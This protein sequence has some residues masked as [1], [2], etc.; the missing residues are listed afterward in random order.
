MTAPL[1]PRRRFNAGERAAL[2]VSADGRCSDC[3]SYL[4]P[5]FHADHRTPHARGGATHVRNGAAACPTCNL[6][7]GPNTMPVPHRTRDAVRQL[8]ST[9]K[10][11]AW[12]RRV[13]AQLR[14]HEERSFLIDA[15]PGGGKTVPALIH[16]RDEIAAGR[17]ERIVIVTPT[18][19][20]ARQWALAAHALGLNIEPNWRGVVEPTNFHGIAI[21]YQRLLSGQLALAHSCREKTLVI[22]DEPHHL[23]TN[24]AWA[25]SFA[26]AFEDAPKWL[27]L[28]GTPFR[29][30]GLA[31]PGVTYEGGRAKADFSYSYTEAIHDG[32]CRAV[33]FVPYDGQLRWASDGTVI[34]ADF[35]RNLD[36]KESARRHRT[37]ISATLSDGLARMIA[38][39]NSQ[40]DQVRETH[41]NAGMLIVC[42]NI[43][44]AEQASSIAEK[45]CGEPATL[46]TSDDPEASAQI[47]AYAKGTSRCIVAVN[48]VSEGVDIPRLRVG[49]YAT[50]K[51][52]AMLFRQIVGRFTRTGDS[53]DNDCSF[54]FLPADPT[55]L[56][57]AAEVQAEIS[58]PLR[59]E[60]PE[61]LP[62]LEDDEGADEALDGGSFVPL[63]ADVH[64]Q[65]A[66]L[67]GAL[68]EDPQLAYAVDVLARRQGISP[69]EVLRSLPGRQMPQDVVASIDE[70]EFERRARLAKDRDRLARRLAYLAGMEFKDVHQTV[71][72]MV[73]GGKPVK[74][75]TVDQLTAGIEHLEREIA[76]AQARGKGMP[77]SLAG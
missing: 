24:K 47:E 1:D 50:P 35:N 11:R 23:G 74:E 16:A 75:H 22:A 49:V 5:S 42:E 12:Q 19:N 26:A 14:D 41:A 70:P 53:A 72:G 66:L 10:P 25:D 52:T 46:V 3:G 63:A 30:D 56:Q 31:I 4:D 62:E 57:L 21:T 48:M 33:A 71:N 20:L 39:A 44:H 13:L 61:Q 77:D 32:V 38:E 34:E 67:S 28:S 59:E 54:I 58:V 73:A 76:R 51:K 8:P 40:L 9:L 65:G 6:K 27:L 69:Q 60:E 2:F 55:L 45:I 17:F 37:A 15:A 36:R 43:A 7:K 29:S 18:A 68:V 64:A